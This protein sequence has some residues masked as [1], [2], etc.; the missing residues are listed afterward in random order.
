M[1]ISSI[2]YG[3]VDATY[4]IAG[5][6]N[7]SQGFRDNFAAIK[8][9]LQV[10]DANFTDLSTN[11]AKLNADNNF[12]GVL[13]DNAV[14]NRL[15][16]TVNN[17]GSGNGTIN[18]SFDDGEYQVFTITGSSTISFQDWPVSDRYAKIRV[19]LASDTVS[20]RTISAFASE[21]AVTPKFD[22][23]FPTPFTLNISGAPKIIEAWTYNGGTTVY[24]KYLGE[25]E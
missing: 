19:H 8:T 20:S 2:V 24:I 13:V 12:N 25:F 11:T 6:D 10:A 16:G 7:N 5:Q 18:V 9:G 1:T 4:P 3:N 21:G 17:A 14:T 23:N 22:D 15:T